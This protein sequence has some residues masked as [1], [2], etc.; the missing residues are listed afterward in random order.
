MLATEH[1]HH[2]HHHHQQQQQQQH[3]PTHYHQHHNARLLLSLL[4]C[5]FRLLPLI[6][7]LFRFWRE[8][9]TRTGWSVPHFYSDC[10]AA[11]AATTTRA[12]S[13]S[14][15]PPPRSIADLI[16]RFID[17]DG[18]G[19]INAEELAVAFAHLGIEVACSCCASRD[20]A[21]GSARLAFDL[22]VEFHDRRF[23]FVLLLTLCLC[24]L[25]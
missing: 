14:T 13:S 1:H 15:N 18:S 11:A 22:F 25:F 21:S 16:F 12:I 24:K 10:A 17:A 3:H 20:V 2:H 6:Y 9:I 4:A 23:C 19:Q 5:H 7:R 8:H